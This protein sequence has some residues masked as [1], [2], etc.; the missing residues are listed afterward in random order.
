ML[1]FTKLRISFFCTQCQENYGLKCMICFNMPK[2]DI[3]TFYTWDRNL[4]IYICTVN[5]IERSINIREVEESIENDFGFPAKRLSINL[6]PDKFYDSKRRQYQSTSILKELL[7]NFPPDAMKVIGIVPF[8]LFIPILTF[9]FGEAQLNGKVAVVSTARLEQ[10]FYGMPSNQPLLQ[11]RLIK[12]IKHEL[13]HT[14]GLLHCPQRLCV[15]SLANNVAHVDFKGLTFCDTCQDSLRE[16]R[17]NIF[18]R[19]PQF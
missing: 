5:G 7:Y 10:D 1:Y 6:T 15:M 2:D 14:F 3:Y 9:V 11:R 16:N 17:G 18:N 4:T 13:G 12:E 19:T 8:D